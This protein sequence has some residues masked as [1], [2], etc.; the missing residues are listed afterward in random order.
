MAQQVSLTVDDEVKAL[1]DAI[2]GLI[3][4][5]KGK[6]ALSAVL[7]DSI[8]NLMAAVGGF[9]AF[10][11]DLKKGDNQIYLVKCIAEP[12]EAVQA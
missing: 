11:G 7:A 8:P 3:A 5:I 12:L 2:A 9:A 6:K 10:G 4:D 1:G